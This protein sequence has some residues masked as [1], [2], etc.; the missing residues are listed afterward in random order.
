[1][2]CQ[3]ASTAKV[4]R[5]VVVEIGRGA[6]GTVDDHRGYQDGDA[7]RVEVLTGS[8]PDA[9]I[10]PELIASLAAEG[11]GPQAQP[12]PRWRVYSADGER[13]TDWA[14]VLAAPR[15]ASDGA[16]RVRNAGQGPTSKAG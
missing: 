11:W 14:A 16:I 7:E 5:A 9:P 13:V 2:E 1:M 3:P 6:T 4:L 8:A 12:Q 10:G 15:A